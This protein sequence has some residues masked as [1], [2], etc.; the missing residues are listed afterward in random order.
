MDE[1]YTCI[2]EKHPFSKKRMQKDGQEGKLVYAELKKP[3]NSKQTQKRSGSH[4]EKGS[5][6]P[7]AWYLTVVILGV[8]CFVLL[9]STGILGF[10][11]FQVCQGDQTQKTPLDNAPAEDTTTLKNMIF[12]KKG[13]ESNTCKKKWSCCGEDCYYFSRELKTFDD[14]KKFCK[15]MDS[16]LLKIEDQEEQDF[17]QSQISYFFWIGLSRKGISSSWTWEDDSQLHLE[18]DWKESKLGNCGSIAAT[19]M[20][21]SDCSRF[22]YY[23]CEKKITCLAT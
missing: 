9:L 13:S 18:L 17:I 14:S 16:M 19:K 12:T 7:F 20:A 6:V 3:P 22:M 23:I 8:S 2:E 4:E 5:S 15:E 21:P 10:M 1:K 11:V